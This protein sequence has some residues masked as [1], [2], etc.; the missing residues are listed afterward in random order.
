MTDEYGKFTVEHLGKIKQGIELFNR[1]KYWECHEYLEDH[2]FEDMGD[3]ARLVYWAVIQVACSM[4]HYRDGNLSG[5]FGMLK[6][7][8]GK[9]VQCKEKGVETEL[10]YKTLSWQKLKNLVFSI[11]DDAPIE[12]YKKLYTFRFKDPSLW[13]Y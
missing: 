3:N 5:A 6:K 12:E 11:P 2:W 9:F 8:K 7:A 4:I 10:L 13:E 1:Q